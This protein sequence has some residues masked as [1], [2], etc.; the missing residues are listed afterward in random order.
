[1][2]PTVNIDNLPTFSHPCIGRK[3]LLT[4][5]DSAFLN[6]HISVL[7]ITAAAGVGKS[8]V[9]R[10]WLTSI[11]PD[12]QGAC[13]VFGWS[14]YGQGN[15]YPQF[16]SSIFFEQAL[17]FFGHQ[18]ALP[19]NDEAKAKRL[20]ELLHEQAFI[21]VLDGIEPL[22]YPVSTKGGVCADLGFKTFLQELKAQSFDEKQL[23]LLTSRQ[24][25]IELQ[26][27]DS[28]SVCHLNVDNLNA[29]ESANFLKLLGVQGTTW[30]L[31]GLAKLLGGHA[32][33][34]SLLGG[35][36]VDAY[37]NDLT[38]A[39]TQLPALFADEEWGGQALRVLRFY[40]ENC[41]A[42][43]APERVFLQLLS[44]FDRA[45]S[46]AEH[47]VLFRQAKLA[48][49]V[50]TC[51]AEEWQDIRQRLAK[52]GLLYTYNT[53]NTH[54]WD[55][56]PV[57]R[58]YFR[59]Q[60][61]TQR[62]DLWEQAH[63]VLFQ[64]FQT[65]LS[66]DV[67]DTFGDLEPLYRAVAHGCMA[68]EYQAAM[69]VYSDSILHEDAY[70]SINT[71]GS[72][73]A[74]LA[75]L[76]HFFPQKNWTTPQSTLPEKEQAFL[77][78]QTAFL[79]CAL[80]RL[81]EALEPLQAAAELKQRQEDW[82]NAALSIV[83][84]VDLLTALGKLCEAEEVAQQAIEWAERGHHLSSRMQSH[85]KFAAVL[86]Q[87]GDLEYSL[88]AFKLAEQIQQ[89]DQPQHPY[90]YS[91][92]GAQYC[93]LLLDMAQ[94]TAAREDIL[95]RGQTILTL[96]ESELGVSSVAFANLSMGRI[97]S[98][99]QKPVDALAF[100]NNVLQ[101]MRQTELFLFMPEALLVRANIYRQLGDILRA[102]KDIN[103]TI[104]IVNRTNMRLYEV[105]ARLLQTHLILDAQ[106]KRRLPT[107]AEEMS[108]KTEKLYQ[109]IVRLIYHLNNGLHVA[110]L[111][112]LNARIA[113]YS[114]RQ[115]DAKDN[116]ELARQR[117][118]SVGQWQLMQTWESIRIEI[119]SA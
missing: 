97:L 51:S 77:F 64:Y 105:E 104:E 53:H 101:D 42:S 18:G 112:L 55:T 62:L 43:N 87:L 6:K 78:A 30:Q 96:A 80:G 111:S 81:E 72:F 36:L 35:M 20:V 74:D 3:T 89:E 40:D 65:T 45:M 76:A 102:Q 33:A 59:E 61:R 113:Y 118:V 50:A 63:H 82:H 71:F 79:L 90:L 95:Q 5:I 58:A 48:Q 28:K 60:L 66:K 115:T 19:Q 13:F 34:L 46:E 88:S 94:D 108:N 85:A 21:L 109:R 93:N 98:A 14:F 69:L 70:F 54:S 49:S 67:P 2:Q 26:D 15:D 119:E 25:I 16:S 27:R 114:K 8:M 68:G 29:G 99:L 38:T 75:L 84:R 39:P 107:S 106:R 12:Y 17:I 83:N 44:L 57:I 73:S 32:L 41:W 91:L 4:E 22:Q 23:V 37:A 24:P 52:V 10:E 110:D 86:H 11:A 100:L 1:M 9:L 7:T 92:A 47:E 31:V 117:I 116:L 56:H 103:E